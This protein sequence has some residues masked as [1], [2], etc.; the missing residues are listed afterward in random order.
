MALY[1]TLEL[2]NMT[3]FS[4]IPKTIEYTI[5]KQGKIWY[6]TAYLEQFLFCFFAG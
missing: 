6:N 3:G 4:C 5:D 1:A 2:C